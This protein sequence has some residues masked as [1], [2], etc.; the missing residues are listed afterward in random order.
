MEQ[1]NRQAAALGAS[2]VVGVRIGHTIRPR[3]LNSGMGGGFGGRELRG[4]MVTFNAVGTAI[5]Q[6]EH[7]EIQAPE[8]V[9]DLFA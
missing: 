8:P 6:H 4:M 7:A 9:V 3:S 2:G 5:R 1:I